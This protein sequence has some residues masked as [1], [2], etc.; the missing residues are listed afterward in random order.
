MS[1]QINDRVLITNGLYKDIKGT[2]MSENRLGFYLV[3]LDFDLPSRHYSEKELK[4]IER[5]DNCLI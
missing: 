1:L 2:I 4:K 3:K 5:E